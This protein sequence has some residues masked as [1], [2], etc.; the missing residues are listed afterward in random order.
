MI[1]LSDF[2]LDAARRAQA[3]IREIHA[4]GLPLAAFIEVAGPMAGHAAETKAR[5]DALTE[6][7]RTNWPAINQGIAMATAQVQTPPGA[8]H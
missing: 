5:A 6:I 7:G 3:Y 1:G 8:H 2:S 4:L